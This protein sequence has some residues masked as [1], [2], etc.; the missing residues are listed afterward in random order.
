MNA[1]LYRNASRKV[2]H[3]KGYNKQY[4]SFSMTE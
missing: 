4:T 2:K 1:T 3:E